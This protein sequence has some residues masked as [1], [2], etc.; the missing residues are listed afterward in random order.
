MTY[1]TDEEL[2]ALD[3]K[4]ASQIGDDIQMIFD[5]EQ[6]FKQARSTITAL[7]TQLA[8]ANARADRAEAALAAQINAV[9][10][11]TGL[12]DKDGREICLGDR[13]RHLNAS[14]LTKQE[15]WFPEYEVIW[16][17]PSFRLKHTGGG[18]SSDPMFAFKYC[19]KEFEAITAQPHDRS[20]KI[21]GA[22]HD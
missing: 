5:H 18:K 22:D 12:F 20:D 4:L 6:L 1:S 16:D 3:A 2:D 13:L 19:S 21:K 15:Y 11:R 7:R 9:P 17:A 10:L 8:E 14:P